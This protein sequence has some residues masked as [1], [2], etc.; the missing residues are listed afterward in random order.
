M[1][2]QCPVTP[3]LERSHFQCE[4]HIKIVVDHQ[5]SQIRTIF[6]HMTPFSA[7]SYCSFPKLFEGSHRFSSSLEQCVE[8][9]LTGLAVSSPSIHWPKRFEFVI[10]CQHCANQIDR[11]AAHTY[12][13]CHGISP[14]SF[15]AISTCHTCTGT[16]A[17]CGVQE[18]KDERTKKDRAMKRSSSFLCLS[19]HRTGFSSPPQNCVVV[20]WTCRAR[21]TAPFV[22]RL[23]G[24]REPRQGR[25]RR[26]ESETCD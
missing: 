18:A 9:G 19:T 4:K 3:C 21:A 13:H 1:W 10:H 25:C 15:G 12:E 22:W 6:D 23:V 11:M 2:L 7:D 16:V 26:A 5:I 8:K 14:F 20:L 17:Y 24:R